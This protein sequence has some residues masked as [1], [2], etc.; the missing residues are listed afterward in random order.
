MR[1]RR[2]WFCGG[3]AQRA[4]APATSLVRGG[5]VRMVRV[6]SVGSNEGNEGDESGGAGYDKMVIVKGWMD[7][8]MVRTERR[9]FVRL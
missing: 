9:T 8:R 5:V 4:F 2:F 6:M 1:T 3:F 7:G